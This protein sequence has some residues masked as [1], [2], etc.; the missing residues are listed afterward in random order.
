MKLTPPPSLNRT[1]RRREHRAFWRG[2]RARSGA[3]A[4]KNLV[5]PQDKIESFINRI[6]RFYL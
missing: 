1:E 6:S 2:D 3:K 4:S 5:A